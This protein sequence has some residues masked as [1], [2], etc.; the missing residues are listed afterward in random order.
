MKQLCACVRVMQGVCM[1]LFI[2]WVLGF[3]SAGACSQG[4]AGEVWHH[5]APCQTGASCWAENGRWCLRGDR[6]KRAP[7][8][9]RGCGN[10]R[11]TQSR[12]MELCCCA[13]LPSPRKHSCSQS[14]VLVNPNASVTVAQGRFF[15]SLWP[16]E[17]SSHHDDSSAP[18]LP[19]VWVRRLV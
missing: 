4:G 15:S 8:A 6:G 5:S 19:W 7:F 11:F 13:H 3:Y 18:L 1:F 2:H 16:V 17:Q 14:K 12:C 9:G 10:Q